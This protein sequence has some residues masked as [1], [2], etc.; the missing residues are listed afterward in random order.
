MQ[1]Y[2][3]EKKV[4]HPRRLKPRANLSERMRGRQTPEQ[5]YG[6]RRK[7]M[8]NST[9]H[10]GKSNNETRTTHEF[11]SLSPRGR[12]NPTKGATTRT[13]KTLCDKMRRC[14][15]QK[16]N[17]AN[18]MSTTGICRFVRVNT[19]VNPHKRTFGLLRGQASWDWKG[20]LGG[21]TGRPS[22]WA[23]LGS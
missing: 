23:K 12:L 16:G 9:Y 11:N 20:K 8:R 14:L 15:T 22:W 18:P 13:D 19:R 6:V 7:G 1:M 17:D 10:Q 21:Q 4:R 2:P 3:D 5:L